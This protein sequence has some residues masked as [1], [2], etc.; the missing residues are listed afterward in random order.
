[1]TENKAVIVPDLIVREK[2]DGILNTRFFAEFLKDLS[3]ELELSDGEG[4][5]MEILLTGNE[6]IRELNRDFRNKDQVTDVLSFVDGDVLPDSGE[7]FLGSVV[8]SVERA[9]AQSQ[10][11]G[12]SFEEELKFL[13]L[14]GVLHLLGFDHEEDEG[15]MLNLQKKL[16]NALPTHF[17]GEE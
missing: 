9:R 2:F 14:H 5:R 4:C 6:E 12:N 8:I 16:K 3:G 11:I 13:V 10:E 17:K 15:E 1:M 7:I